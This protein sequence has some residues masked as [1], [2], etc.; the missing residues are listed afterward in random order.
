MTRLEWT[1]PAVADLDNIHD[2]IARDSV[3]YAQAV[4]ERL[5]H[6]VERLKS[7]PESGR[8]VPEAATP[9]VREVVTL[10][11]RIIYRLRKGRAQ[12]LA[13]IHSARNLAGLTP[14]P[15]DAA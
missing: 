11:Y 2:Y 13:V 5:I 4:I 9:S 6:A 3:E 12:I 8:I 10:G 1:D 15:W 14:K 7:F